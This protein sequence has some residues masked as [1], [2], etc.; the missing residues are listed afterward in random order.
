MNGEEEEEEEDEQTEEEEEEGGWVGRRMEEAPFTYP[1][2]AKPVVACGSSDSHQ[3]VIVG[4]REG[5]RSLSRETPMVLQVGW[6]VEWAVL[7]GIG[8]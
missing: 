3:L 7:C 8:R 2:I 1:L 5:L 6:V 4:S